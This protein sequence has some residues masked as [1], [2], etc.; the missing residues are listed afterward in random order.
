MDCAKRI[1]W[2]NCSIPPDAFP[3]GTCEEIPFDLL[4][5]VPDLFCAGL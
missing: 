5:R 1:P 2:R 4:R 3:P